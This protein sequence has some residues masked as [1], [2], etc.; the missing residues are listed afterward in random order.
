MRSQIVL[1]DLGLC[2]FKWPWNMVNIGTQQRSQSVLRKQAITLSQKILDRPGPGLGQ[3]VSWPQPSVA[4][5]KL[6]WLTAQQSPGVVRKLPVPAGF[7]AHLRPVVR[8][9][10]EAAGGENRHQAACVQREKIY[11]RCPGA[12]VPNIGPQIEFGKLPR[13]RNRRQPAYP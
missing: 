3:L 7:D 9:V 13:S 1:G 4:R 10:E 5:R 11:A 6:H 2:L 8:Q 12:A